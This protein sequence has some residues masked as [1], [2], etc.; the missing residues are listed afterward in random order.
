MYIYIYDKNI[1]VMRLFLTLIVLL[2]LPGISLDAQTSPRAAWGNDNIRKD[3]RINIDVFP[4]P[5]THFISLSDATGVTKIVLYNMVGGRVRE[6]SEI[7]PDAR[8]SLENLP[9]GMYLVQIVGTNNVNLAVKRL[10]KQ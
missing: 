7:A 1:N 4:N 6:F 5:A 3:F 2:M 9:R 10:Y 8:Y